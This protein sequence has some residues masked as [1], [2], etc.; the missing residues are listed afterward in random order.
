MSFGIEFSIFKRFPDDNVLPL[1]KLKA[2]ADDNLNVAQMV[3]FFLSKGRKCG[4][5]RK[6]W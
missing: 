5:M 2:F 3:H 6:C 4:K 1:S